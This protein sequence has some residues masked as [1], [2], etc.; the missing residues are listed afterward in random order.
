MNERPRNE[1]VAS[2]LAEEL[3]GLI[4]RDLADPRVEGVII[5]R[6]S[7]TPDLKSARIYFRL[8]V[9]ADEP[10]RVEGAQKG[11]ERA[12]ARLKKTAA[13]RLGLRWVP[14]LR[15]FYDEGQDARDRIE[16]LLDEVRRDRKDG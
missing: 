13:K 12:S 16:E 8:A 10:A 15:F 7:M 4:S 5:S 6:V 2:E 11:L 3:A 14:E 9:G 1:R